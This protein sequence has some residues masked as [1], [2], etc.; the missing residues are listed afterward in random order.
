[1]DYGDRGYL[2]FRNPELT[3]NEFL[4]EILVGVGGGLAVGIPTLAILGY[5]FGVLTEKV[6]GLLYKVRRLEDSYFHKPPD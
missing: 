3:M 5:R 6:E 2:G 1:M 4:K